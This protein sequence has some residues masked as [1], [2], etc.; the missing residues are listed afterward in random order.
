MRRHYSA[1]TK[2]KPKQD[3]LWVPELEIDNRAY[4][5]K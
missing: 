2:H 3:G 1:M 4:H 5:W